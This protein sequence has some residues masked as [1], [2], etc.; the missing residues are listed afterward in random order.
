MA[1]GPEEAQYRFDRRVA[2]TERHIGTVVLLSV[3]AVQ[4]GDPAMVRTD[5][6]EQARVRSWNEK[7]AARSESLPGD[8]PV[9]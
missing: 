5:S 6:D 4:I 3:L 8:N 9:S 2:L 7:Q 1:L